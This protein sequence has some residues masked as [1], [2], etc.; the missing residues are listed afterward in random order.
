ME[1]EKETLTCSTMSPLERIIRRLAGLFIIISLVL[2]YTVSQYWLLF[3]L[4]VG[5]NLFQSSFTNFCPLEIFLKLK[6]GK[7]K[8]A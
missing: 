4:F 3:T 2:S 7:S 1:T 8:K 5:V 6:M